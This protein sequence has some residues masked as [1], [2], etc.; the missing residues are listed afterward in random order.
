M[1]LGRV[2]EGGGHDQDQDSSKGIIG[3]AWRSMFAD[4][5]RRIGRVSTRINSKIFRRHSVKEDGT[6]YHE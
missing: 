3:A 5:L 2:I 6:S 1:V 4:V